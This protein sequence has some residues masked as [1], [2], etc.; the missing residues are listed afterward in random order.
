MIDLTFAKQTVAMSL[1][2]VALVGCGVSNPPQT[3][4]SHLSQADSQ[5]VDI[6]EPVTQLPYLPEPA[7]VKPEET[8]TVVV[9]QVPVRELL[10]ALARDARLD[11]DIKGDIR[12][13]VTMNAIDQTLPK[14]LERISL[15]APIRYE[16]R[17]KVLF[18]GP[19][20]PY[21]HNYK[22]DYLNIARKNVSSVSLATQVGSI[23]GNLSG[24]ASGTASNSSQTSITNA[25]EN[26]FWASLQRNIVGILG[27]QTNIEGQSPAG[28]NL[29]VNRESGIVSV[30]G[31][32]AQHK[33]IKAFLDDVI[34]SSRRQ[35]LIEATVVEVQLN[36][37][38]QAGIDWSILQETGEDGWNLKQVL[39]DGRT[40]LTTSTSSD[41]E[42][43]FTFIDKDSKF[44][45]VTATLK[46]LEQFGDVQILSS[47]KV[48][49]LNNQ[50]AVLKVVD[51]RVYFSTSVERE[52]FENG[53]QNVQFETQIHTVPVGLVMSVTPFINDKEEV[54]LNVRPTISRIL[55]FTKDPNPALADAK[56]SSLIPEI[57]V[58]EMESMLRVNTGD[59][60]IIGGL[61]QD[62]ID[63]STAQ[64]PG[65]G[66]VPLLGKLFS[67]ESEEVTK[68]E[69]L[70]FI[71][72]TIVNN[73]SING[74]LQQ[75]RRYLPSE[76]GLKPAFKNNLRT[77]N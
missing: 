7:Q 42:A 16:Q 55:G 32:Q 54:L 72:P 34:A 52:T 17:D 4:E 15:Q 53:N 6:P 59:V 24:E 66:R 31:T 58:R 65:L 43:L 11:I 22:V 2:V 23:S 40:A 61:M 67:Y 39:G 51:N 44:G 21:V 57:Q 3:S 64:V 47:P 68:T 12:G 30:R 50:P 49:A 13:S 71:R 18:I 28:N 76:E 62:R 29:F 37:K 56:V 74:D 8:Y 14:I 36:D 1:V 38:F 69:L 75:F 9:N 35:A 60:A 46:L 25:S 19:D 45:M 33:E 26:L 77:G 41:P 48:V 70:V 20:I 63:A 10:F 73:A 5:Q 27:L